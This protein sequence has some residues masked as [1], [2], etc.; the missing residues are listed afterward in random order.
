MTDYAARRE[1]FLGLL[2]GSGPTI[3]LSWVLHLIID[4]NNISVFYIYDLIQCGRFR[5]KF[6]VDL[7]YQTYIFK[8][9]YFCR[10]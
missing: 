9:Q 10:S 5:T 2:G 4:L 7:G 1:L 8:I 6:M 3:T